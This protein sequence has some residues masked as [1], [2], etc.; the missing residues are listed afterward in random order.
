MTMACW[1]AMARDTHSQYVIIIDFTLQQ[2]LHDCVLSSVTVLLKYY[3]EETLFVPGQVRVTF[4]A[5][6]VAL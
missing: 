6:K 4:V 2:L 1:I 5:D 3:S